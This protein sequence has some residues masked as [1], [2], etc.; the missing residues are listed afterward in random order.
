MDKYHYICREDGY[1][2]GLPI[3]VIES[4][5]QRDGY[6]KSMADLIQKELLSFPNANE[7]ISS[8]FSL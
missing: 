4:W 7:V 5:Y 1:F 2:E 8:S 3:S 6:I